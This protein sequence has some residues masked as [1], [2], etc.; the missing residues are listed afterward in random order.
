MGLEESPIL[1]GVDGSAADELALGWAVAEARLRN[2]SL[3]V[4][5]AYQWLPTYRPFAGATAPFAGTVPFAGAVGLTVGE[6]AAAEYRHS[7]RLAEEV[8]QK[9]LWRA[10][11]INR[12]VPL[13]GEAIEGDAASIL[14]DESAR[15]SLL[16]TG[17]RQLEAFG[18]YFLGSVSSAVAARAGCPVIV[19]RGIAGDP[20]E[21]PSVVVGVDGTEASQT[22]LAFS[23]DYASRHRLP[24]RAILCWHPDLLA[25]M[26]WRSEP[27]APPRAEAWLAEALGGWKEK[28]PD[29]L[30]HSGVVRDHPTAGLVDASLNR[31]LLVVGN[32]GHHASIGMLL[33][34]VSQGVLHHAYCPVA[35]VPTHTD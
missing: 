11:E 10:S 35:V 29:V 27:P 1:V 16:V 14:I 9:A 31:Y 23:F 24:L 18:S 17:S 4:V 25:S 8:L 28:F 3:R 21:L 22:L 12:T 13:Q 7:L 19:V 26:K 30:V 6:D 34:S 2:V 5:C 15:A 33:G 32:R 20:A